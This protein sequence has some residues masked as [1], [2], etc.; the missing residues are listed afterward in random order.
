MRTPSNLPP[1]VTDA[2]IEEQAG[3][4]QELWGVWATRHATSV[5]GYACSWCKE[6]GKEL[7][8]ENK[9]EAQAYCDNLMQNK[10]SAKVSYRV[11]RYE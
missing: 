7:T 10:L 2:M 6:K 8:W 1:G 11:E 9:A 5:A 3:A 4:F